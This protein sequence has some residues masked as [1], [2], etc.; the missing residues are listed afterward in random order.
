[1]VGCLFARDDAV[2][3][4]TSRAAVLEPI[5]VNDNRAP[6]GVF[7]DGVL[8]R[9]ALSLTRCFGEDALKQIR[10]AEAACPET[11]ALAIQ[12]VTLNARNRLDVS[13]L[14]LG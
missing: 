13:P 7:R 1:M 3:S 10:D 12:P 9:E 8:T 2:A 14:S 4:P 11:K 5:A 6:A